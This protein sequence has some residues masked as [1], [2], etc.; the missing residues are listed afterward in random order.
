MLQIEVDCS[1][2]TYIRS[3]AHDLG[4]ALGCGAHLAGLVRLASGRFTVEEAESL[5][6]VLDSFENNY[7]MY[8]LHPLDEALLDYPAMIV[9]PETEKAIRHGQQVP[10]P[11][12]EDRALCRVYAE[13][14]TFIGLVR[15]EAWCELWQPHMVFPKPKERTAGT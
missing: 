12:A 1:K 6:T 10:G 13:D 11:P 15:Y 5:E 2:G 8:L 4:E 9:S 3:L 14:G 7:W